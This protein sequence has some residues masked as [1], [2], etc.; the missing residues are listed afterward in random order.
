[1]QGSLQLLPTATGKPLRQQ[2]AW[3]IA[4][5]NS[6]TILLE[7]VRWGVPL[8]RLVIRPIPRSFA[9][10]TLR[11]VLVTETGHSGAPANSSDEPK[12]KT[13][14]R[15]GIAFGQI[16][17][18]I[19][20]PTDAMILPAVHDQELVSLLP[21]DDSEYLWHPSSGL[22]RMEP[23]EVLGIVDF[24]KIPVED[25]RRWD[26]ASPGIL[27]RSRLLEV[28][29]EQPLNADEVLEESAGD[30]GS[31]P[32]WS[33]EVPTASFGS[34]QNFLA[35]LRQL[36]RAMISR[37]FQ[38][39]PQ[40]GTNTAATPP[41][42]RETP[43]PKG[44]LVGRFVTGA[45]ELASRGLGILLKPLVAIGEA[46]KNQLA[47]SSLGERINQTARDRE[48]A[49]LLKR[50]NTDPDEGLRYAFP[51]DGLDNGRGKAPTSNQ[52][53]PHDIDWT[54]TQ[55]GA[56]QLSD[57]WQISKPNLVRL[58]AQYRQLA[59]RELQLG[60]FRRA[61]YIFSALLGDHASAAGALE[62]GGHYREAAAIYRD[63]L[64]RSADA[65]RCLERAGLLDEAARLYEEIGELAKAAELHSRLDRPDQAIRLYRILVFGL[66][67]Q[68]NFL[69]ASRILHERLQDLEGALATLSRG[70]PNS[71]TAQACLHETISLLGAHQRHAD[72]LVLIRQL[73]AEYCKDRNQQRSTAIVLSGVAIDYP[74]GN[75]RA[76]AC[77]TVQVI[78]AS[79]LEAYPLSEASF[80]LDLLKKMIPQ[81]KLLDRD[82]DR[83]RQQ[84]RPSLPTS[85]LPPPA[86]EKLFRLEVFREPSAPP[87][88]WRNAKSSGNHVEIIGFQN[89]TLILR[90]SPW[91]QLRAGSELNWSKVNP[92][93]RLIFEPLTNGSGTTYVHSTEYRPLG[94]Q[95]TTYLEPPEIDGEYS[96][97]RAGSP[98]RASNRT[99]AIAVEPN[100]AIW[101]IRAGND[102]FEL[103][104]INIKGIP[105]LQ[106][107]LPSFTNPL[108]NIAEEIVFLV[109][110]KNLCYVSI[111]DQIFLVT[112]KISFSGKDYGP[113]QKGLPYEHFLSLPSIPE[114]LLGG[115]IDSEAWLLVL[116]PVG[117]K[118]VCCADRDIH[119]PI[120]ESLPTPKGLILLEKFVVI[121]ADREVQVYHIRRRRLFL[122]GTCPIG[123]TPIAVTSTVN[124]CEFAVFGAAGEIE[125]F[126]V[127]R[128]KSFLAQRNGK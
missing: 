116:Y 113:T 78:V 73:R 37:V 54:N 12:E 69:A 91:H 57:R 83:F 62:Q 121:A 36:V 18:R 65:A 122:L 39:K 127:N 89:S 86:V 21:A 51:I 81:D 44:G 14:P 94:F 58:T 49:R 98:P 29:A 96:E 115:T 68:H 16:G 125:A 30:I 97:W 126:V 112:T 23:S 20:L 110:M 63:R 88:E 93:A 32:L 74:E 52:L 117:G 80:F 128:S 40:S 60:R 99:L 19:F 70:W 82:C 45:S 34:I 71:T 3:F 72:T 76:A 11:G 114:I 5:G 108:R 24:L 118:L 7:F 111:Y 9:D 10:A 61:A 59:I 100:G 38:R 85:R 101:E 53:A 109:V 84:R 6:E 17:K 123:F 105:F 67:S 42:P 47:T 25:F 102:D 22:I 120:A 13:V 28:E 41:L 64:N 2:V 77:D 46:M 55:S 35:G 119:I 75:V 27:F 106:A 95:S 1:M 26:P 124:L 103:Y 43:L 15:N 31:E 48:I 56:G 33:D 107:T 50:L 92:E 104:F 87:T 8:E 79:A 4:G 66:I 90:K